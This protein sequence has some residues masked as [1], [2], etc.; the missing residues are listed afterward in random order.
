[1][2]ESFRRH[3]IDES[4]FQETSPHSKLEQQNSVEVNIRSDE[5][6]RKQFEPNLQ[7]G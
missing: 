5:M 3:K 7:V 4:N 6:E 2:I 1:M